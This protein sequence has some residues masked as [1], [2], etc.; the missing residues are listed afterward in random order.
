[1]T[2]TIKK[3]LSISFLSIT[4][5]FII[6]FGTFSGLIVSLETIFGISIKSDCYRY[7]FWPYLF[8]IF[9]ISLNVGLNSFNTG[10]IKSE[11]NDTGS[12]AVVVTSEDNMRSS[13]KHLL[14]GGYPLLVKWLLIKNG[15]FLYDVFARP[16]YWPE[17]PDTHEE[18]PIIRFYKNHKSTEIRF[19]KNL[20]RKVLVRETLL[21]SHTYGEFREESLFKWKILSLVAPLKFIMQIF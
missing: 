20:S 4:G 15:I 11:N 5:P 9:L 8:Y 19:P 21:D 7:Y 1:M 18:Y 2:D 3:I 13:W 17:Y 10:G 12:D 14:F 6:L 16:D